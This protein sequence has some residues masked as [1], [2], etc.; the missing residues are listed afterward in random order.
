MNVTRVRLGFDDSYFT[1]PAVNPAWPGTYLPEG[2]VPPIS[3]LWVDEGHDPDGFGFLSDP[4]A[5]AANRFRAALRGRRREGRPAGEPDGDP[6]DRR[7]TWPPSP[8]HPWARSSSAPSRSAT[9]RPPRCSPATSAWPR[10]RRAPSRP[11]PPRCSRCCGGSAYPPPATGC[12][13]AAGSRA[14]TCSRTDSLA[15]VVRLATSADHPE[16][17][18]V[19]TGLPVAGFTGSLS[20]RFDKGPDAGPGAG[21]CEDRDPHR[22]ARPRRRRRRRERCPDGL[23]GRGRPGRAAEEPRGA[24]ADRPD[25]RRAGR[26][27]VRRRVDAMS[28]D[29]PNRPGMVDWDLAVRVGSRLVGEGPQVSRAEAVDAVEELRAGAERSSPLVREYTGLVASERTAPVLVVDRPGW[30]QAN[31]DGFATVIAPADRQAAGEEGRARSDD[32]GDRLADHRRRAGR[33]ARLPRLEGAGP[34]RPVPREARRAGAAAARRAQHRARRAR[35][36]GRPARLPALGVPARG[37]PPGAVHGRA[38]DDRPPALARWARSWAPYRPTRPSCSATRSARSA[39]WCRARPRAA[40]ST[41]SPAPSRRPSSS[42]SP[43]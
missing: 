2:V 36:A 3:A 14:R 12:T 16:L 34:V 18:Q 1:G 6:D 22:R 40:C 25:R 20:Y 15:G 41:C 39:T 43:A 19:L 27:Q 37:D 5:G 42:G 8:A 31:A 11:A 4:A 21:A 30:I 29:R 24:D 13:T 26:V 7:P 32:R 23:R 38:V 33:D 28:A 9:T 17:R 10:S 35:A